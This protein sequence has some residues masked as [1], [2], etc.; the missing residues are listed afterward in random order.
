V[1]P[2][3]SCQEDPIDAFR[4]DRLTRALVAPASRRRLLG[5]LAGPL[6]DAATAKQR[7]K[8]VKRNAFGC[9]NVGKFCKHD[10]QCCSGICKGK[11]GKKRCRAHGQS[12]CR[13]GQDACTRPDV[14]CLSST[15]ESG[16]CF[17][18][19]GKASFCGAD[20]DCFAC[21]KD[22]DCIPVCGPQAACIVCVGC[23]EEVGTDTA[24]ESP[25]LDDPC[26]FPA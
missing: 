6:G 17:V 23:A 9:V 10:G 18:T 25:S 11:K 14:D 7:R 5:G 26:V 20:G 24:C 8:K 2:G 3:Q 1:T 15:G 16:D 4:F 21:T 22:A 19:T 13:R 12:T